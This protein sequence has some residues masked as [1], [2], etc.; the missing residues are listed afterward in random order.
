MT[1]LAV[2]CP[3]T[4]AIRSS[5]DRLPPPARWVP[6]LGLVTRVTVVGVLAIFAAVAISILVSVKI[7]EAEMY[8]RA[9]AISRS[10]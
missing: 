5:A 2:A 10:T 8:R 1:D 4:E 6:H 3:P 9:Q 7:T